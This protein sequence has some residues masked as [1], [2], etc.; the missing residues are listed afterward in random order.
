LYMLAYDAMHVSVRMNC[1]R[2]CLDSTTDSA[3][4]PRFQQ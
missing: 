4:L 2:L 3:L 1:E